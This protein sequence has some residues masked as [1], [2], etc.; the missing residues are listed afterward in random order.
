MVPTGCL[1][2]GRAVST[3]SVA[4][5]RMVLVSEKIVEYGLYFLI[6]F[7]PFAFGTVEP[8]S[9]AT[10][11]VVI[12]TIALAWGFTMVGRGEIRI[13]KTSLNLCWLFVLGFGLFQVLPLPLQVIRVLS[14]KAYGLYQ[15]MAFDSAFTSSWHTLSLYP[16]ATKQDLL[17]LFALALL[18][19]VVANHLR[20]REQVNRVVRLIMAVG[21]LLAIFGIIQHFTWNG[22][23]YWVRELTQGGWPFGPYVNRN[24]FAGY[25]EMVIPLSLG[26]LFA[27]ERDRYTGMSG[28]RDRLLRW[29]TPEA[30]RLLLIYFGGLIMVAALLLTGSRAGLFSFLG[31]MLVV[32]LLLSVRQVRSRRWWPLLACFVMLGFAYA[33]WLNSE[34]VLQTFA[35][36]RLGTDDPSAHFRLLVW[37]DTLRLGRD[38][39]WT[40]TGLNTFSW[41]F[42]PY[43][44]PMWGQR[45]YTHTEND[46]LQAFAE[47][48]LPFLTLLVLALILG[49]TQLLSGWSRSQGSHERG[50]GL[51]LLGGLVAMLLHSASD[52]NLHIMA[53]AML[54]VLLLALATRLLIF[55]CADRRPASLPGSSLSTP[56]A[57]VEGRRGSMA[58]GKIPK[59]FITAIAISA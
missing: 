55:G 38:Y 27:K 50:L 44:R 5:L 28:W 14:P 59:G 20:T 35:I 7:T 25:M 12:F 19:W 30:S 40:G 33:L 21:F 43:Q 52:F 46:Y 56:E 49:G 6:I 9:I 58:V 2:N 15:E 11:E 32:S 24:H 51:G 48:G 29:G 39:R 42:P 22:R 18:F 36:L 23:L 16:Y 4:T 1:M 53:N 41:A 34:K 54:F 47:G 45:H 17:R 37:Q 31:S 10:A 57:V 3:R 26:Y 13:E 8:W